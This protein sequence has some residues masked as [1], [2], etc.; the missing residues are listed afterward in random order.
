MAHYIKHQ[1][2]NLDST[3][4][5]KCV[6]CGEVISDYTKAGVSFQHIPVMEKIRNILI[7]ETIGEKREGD[8]APKGFGAGHV[9]VSVEA[10]KMYTVVIR[11]TDSSTDCSKIAKA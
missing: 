7:E 5:Q 1:V 3:L 10:P 4:I 9:Y 6:H 2:L 8:P 11:D